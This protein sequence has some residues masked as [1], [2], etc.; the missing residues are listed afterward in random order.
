MCASAA[1]LKRTP[2]KR[3]RMVLTNYRKRLKLIKSGLPRLVIRRTN[4]YIIVQ[5]VQSLS[6]GDRTLVTAISKE[7]RKLGWRGGLKNT[8]AAYLTGVLVGTRIKALGVRELIA[9]L[10]LFSKASRL[11]AVIKGV[12]DAGIEVPVSEEVLPSEERLKGAHIRQYFEKIP[13][14]PFMKTFTKVDKE[15]YSRLEAHVEEI[16]QK[17]LLEGSK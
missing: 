3:R 5:A 9:D 14:E 1:L 11:Y 17:I 7:L 4:R 16:K 8:P 13:Q 15:A 2:P 12:I 6:G 10:G